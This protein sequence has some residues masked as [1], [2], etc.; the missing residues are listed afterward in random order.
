M[1]LRGI[2]AV[3]ASICAIAAN[4]AAA[5]PMQ[6]RSPAFSNGG[7][8]PASAT[9]L[10]TGTSPPLQ[11]SHVPRR[12]RELDLLVNDP[13][14]P[15]GRVS[16]WVVYNIP[17][18]SGG[19]PAGSPPA[20]AKQGANSFGLQSYLPPCPQPPG[21]T[22]RYV[23]ELFASKTRLTFASTPNDSEV[24]KALQGNILA[25]ATLTGTFTLP[26]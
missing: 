20:G 19:S 3:A 7:Q 6:L 26:G 15:T 2:V 22:H 9:C 16:H 25:T 13:D 4:A 18:S 17:P 8:L 12:A 10:G 24:R 14:A 23:F 1:R 5:A 11:W 21:S